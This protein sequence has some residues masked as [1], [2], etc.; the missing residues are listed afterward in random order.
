MIE[1]VKVMKL[2]LDNAFE[3]GNLREKYRKQSELV[4]PPDAGAATGRP[5]D[6][7]ELDES[8]FDRGEQGQSGFLM[9][10]AGECGTDDQPQGLFK[11]DSSEQ[12][13]RIMVEDDFIYRHQFS[14]CQVSLTTEGIDDLTN[15]RD[16]S[17]HGVDGEVAFAKVL[18]DVAAAAGREIIIDEAVG[19]D[20]AACLEFFRHDKKTAAEGIGESAGVGFGV[21][22]DHDID[23]PGFEPEQQVAYRAAYKPGRPAC[24]RQKIADGGDRR[25][26]QID[27][28][29]VYLLSTREER[30]QVTS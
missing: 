10:E 27:T 17:R 21:A 5:R 13:E 8:P 12:A 14:S 29:P 11:A 18:D 24:F 2:V 25:F 26:S 20:G 7:A 15:T 22:V 28:Y 9:D 1:D 3:C 16:R 23:I 6:A 30:L 19:A 4:Q